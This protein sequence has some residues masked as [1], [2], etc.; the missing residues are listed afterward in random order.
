M[1]GQ[2][3]STEKLNNTL[4]TIVKLFHEHKISDWF[5]IYGT[6]LGLVR[7]NSCID[8]DDDIDI[9]ANKHNYDKIKEILLKN[10]FKLCYEYL[11]DDSRD[12]IK[13]YMNESYASIDIYM[14]DFNEKDVF[15]KWNKLNITNCYLDTEKKTFVESTWKGEKVYFPNN[16]IKILKNRYGETWNIKIE[17]KVEQTMT[18]L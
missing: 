2:D 11:I 5:V 8:G 6:L 3:C 4:Q 12:I 1:G 16:Y 9:I 7:D 17:G 14:A 13:T 18:M 15:D 10:N